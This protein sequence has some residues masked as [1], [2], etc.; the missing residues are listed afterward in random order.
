MSTADRGVLRNC[1]L[2]RDGSWET[3]A[4]SVTG[5][6]HVHVWQLTLESQRCTCFIL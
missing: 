6:Q 3:K 5:F 1:C 4:E 2:C